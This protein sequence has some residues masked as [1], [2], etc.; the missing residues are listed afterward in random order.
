MRTLR[1]VGVPSSSTLREPR[2]FAIVPSST[3]VTSSEATFWPTRPENAET[4]LRLKSPSRP[5]P[6]A[7]W[8]RM[9][10]QPGPST[11]VIVPAGA[12]TAR[13][14]RTV[15]RRLPREPAPALVLEEEVERDASAAAVG[16]DLAL[17]ALLGDRGHVESRQRP[18][19]AHRPTR[20]RR[21]QRHDLLARERH[22]HL[23]DA[24]IGGPR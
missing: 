20:G 4:S 10:G 6:T 11:T 7:S 21:D 3:T 14:L 13:S 24:R 2:R 17:A 15:W 18:N 5:W 12:S 22:D 16:A 1:P 8:S 23:R 9:P 19:V